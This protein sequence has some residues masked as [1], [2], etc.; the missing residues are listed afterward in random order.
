MS[1][2]ELKQHKRTKKLFKDWTNH[3]QDLTT[4]E[5]IYKQMKIIIEDGTAIRVDTEKE[6]KNK[7][8]KVLKVNIEENDFKTIEQLHA[9]QPPQKSYKEQWYDAFGDEGADMSN[10]V[11]CVSHSDAQKQTDDFYRSWLLFKFNPTDTQRA[12]LLENAYRLKTNQIT[13]IELL[14]PAFPKLKQSLKVA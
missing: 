14:M 10:S 12:L 7:I 5:T 3:T 4:I 2:S 11:L 1:P 13:I 9:E 6:A 8:K